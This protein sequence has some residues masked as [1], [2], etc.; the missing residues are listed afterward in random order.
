MWCFYQFRLSFWQHP[1]T[2]KDSSVSIMMN[3]FYWMRKKDHLSILF[4]FSHT[5]EIT[6]FSHNLLIFLFL[7]FF[8]SAVLFLESM[9]AVIQYF[10]PLQS[11]YVPASY[12]AHFHSPMTLC[13]EELLTPDLHFKG[14]VH[15]RWTTWG[16]AL[17]EVVVYCFQNICLKS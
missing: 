11:R 15:Q 4:S 8:T 12:M 3:L 10:F 17:S 2:V 13:T 5:G 9:W 7:C 16:I 6:T 1:F 14:T